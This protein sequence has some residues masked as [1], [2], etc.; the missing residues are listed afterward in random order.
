M[1]KELSTRIEFLRLAADVLP[2]VTTVEGI[3][4]G[5]EKLE[6]WAKDSR[7]APTKATRRPGI[8]LATPKPNPSSALRKSGAKAPK[9]VAAKA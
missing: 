5:A 1:T 4:E 8:A 3:I 9:R 2:A 7:S 6:A